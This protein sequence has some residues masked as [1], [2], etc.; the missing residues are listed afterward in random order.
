MDLSGIV[1]GENG[2]Q[3]RIELNSRRELSFPEQRLVEQ[4]HAA[5]YFAD[6]SADLEDEDDAQIVGHAHVVK[7]RLGE[8]AVF[9]ILDSLEPDL[10]AVSAAVI[11]PVSGCPTE[12]VEDEVEGFGQDFLILNRVQM[13]KGWRGEALA[14]GLL[15]KS[16]AH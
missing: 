2:G 12:E 8:P 1:D 9:D 11:D 13:A 5:V 3:L 16:L 6:D 14:A 4:W 10:H 7:C 15:Q